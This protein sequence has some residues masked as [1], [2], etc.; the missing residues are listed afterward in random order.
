MKMP[1]GEVTMADTKAANAKSSFAE[2]G[3]KGAVKSLVQEVQA[4][5]Q[6]DE[7]PWV[8]GYSGG[9]DS[10]ATLQLVWLALQQ[11][12]VEKRVKP[13]FVIST[14]TLVEN[15]MV[16]VWVDNS[17]L[18][19]KGAAEKQN[20][21][22]YPHKL[23]PSVGD[24]FWVNLI[25]KGYPA[26]RPKFRWC[27]ER[28]KIKPADTF[29]S[30][31]VQKNG[32]A[33]IVLGSRRAESRSRAGRMKLAEKQRIREKLNPHSSL[34]NAYVYAPIEAWSNDD[35]WLFLMQVPNP[36]NYTNEALLQLYQGASADGECPLVI[37]TTTPSCGDSRFG[38]WVCTMVE[39]D[40]SMSAMIQ[41][42]NDKDWLQPLLDLRNELDEHDHDKRD[43][44]RMA[45]HVQLKNNGEDPIPGPYTQ[46][47]RESWLRKLLKA[48]RIVRDNPRTPD[49][50]KGIQLISIEE[51]HEIRKIW[52]LDKHEV[53]DSL[54]RIYQE[55]MGSNFPA[56]SLYDIQPFGADEMQILRE[57]CGDDELQFELIREL[58]EV[59][60][61]YRGMAKRANLFSRI[62]DAFRRSFYEDVDDATARARR[63]KEFQNLLDGLKQQ[64]LEF[65]KAAVSM[66]EQL[67]TSRDGAEIKGTM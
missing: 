60:R 4:L 28:M 2:M 56:R 22:I 19:L 35:V 24:T 59:E 9:K 61:N 39:K 31:V 5:Y 26:P 49:A 23:T 27:T 33:I 58:L 45:G 67:A 51:L 57:I 47:S 66:S 32:E 54:P 8:V 38:C 34:V 40:K 12:P 6:A 18:A 20:L 52:L 64:E 63:R 41:N 15:P 30:D 44:R 1:T 7:I 53:E 50:V 43:F 55:E 16:A 3:F 14:D 65:S 17:L 36:W 13:V 21:P 46:T 10:T 25:G 11:L 29:I 62:E 42:S 37:D 48:Q